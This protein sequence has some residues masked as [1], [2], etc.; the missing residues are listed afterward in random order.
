MKTATALIRAAP[1]FLGTPYSTI[2]CQA[3]VEAALREIGIRENL[4]GSNAWFRHM[5]WTGTPEE[6]KR[7]F[8]KIPPGAFIFILEHD[9]NE[10]EK[11]RPDGIGNASHIGIYTGMTGDEMVKIAKEAGSTGGSV[12]PAKGTASSTLLRVLGLGDKSK[13]MVIMVSDDEHAHSIVD[14]VRAD[15][16]IQGVVALLG[17]K[18]E[19]GMA[20]K[21]KMITIIVN[22]GYADDIMDAARKAGAGGGTITHARGTASPEDVRFLGVPLVPEKEM[23]MILC[24]SEKT[25]TIVNAI[26]SLKCLDEPGIGILYTQGVSDFMNLGSGK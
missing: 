18:G 25:D 21:W 4:A 22:V 23:I 16:R 2:D 19:D 11:Y 3:F 5:T 7:S 12:I 10:P 1:R 26:A 9:G 17:S 20:T 6:C 15:G 13:D 8:G 24:E 14:D